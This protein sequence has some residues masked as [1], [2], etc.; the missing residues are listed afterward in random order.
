MGCR[1]FSFD[2]RPAASMSS[3][4]A[5]HVYCFSPGRVAKVISFAQHCERLKRLTLGWN[6]HQGVENEHTSSVGKPKANHM[7]GIMI[8]HFN[9]DIVDV[10]CVI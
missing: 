2:P 6:A 7:T 8:M 9:I 3:R 10:I 1:G 4:K 5:Y